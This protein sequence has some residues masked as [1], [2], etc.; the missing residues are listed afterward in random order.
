M[1]ERT[2]IVIEQFPVRRLPVELQRGLDHESVARI[3]IEPMGEDTQ[4]S[5]R[6][7][8]GAA[9]GVYGS[10]EEAVAAIRQLRDEW[11]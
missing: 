4:R 9:P 3:T 10:P 5:L 1:S 7:F 6:S 11:E 8:I 2:K